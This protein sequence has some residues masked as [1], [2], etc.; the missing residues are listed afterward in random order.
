MSEWK[1]IES[2]PRDGTR[3]LAMG[4]YSVSGNVAYEP[5]TVSWCDGSG[6]AFDYGDG[7]V[8]DSVSREYCSDI[9]SMEVA[10]HWQ[11]L[12]TPPKANT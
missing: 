7:L 2:A 1:T 5:A 6:W 4:V 8:V 3:I 9:V 11:P 12:P 10:T